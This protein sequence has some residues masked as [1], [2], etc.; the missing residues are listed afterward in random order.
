MVPES[1]V[2]FCIMWVVGVVLNP[3]NLMAYSWS[4]LRLS[5]TL[6]YIGFLMASN[7]MWVHSL[8]HY[9]YGYCGS[10]ECW[11]SVITGIT[12]SLVAVYLLRN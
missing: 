3:M 9:A 4:H 7:M 5:K 2:I 8:I 11:V 6:I 12:M 10:G 1:I